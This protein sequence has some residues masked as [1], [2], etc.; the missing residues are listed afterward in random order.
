MVTALSE[1]G[2][3]VSL[4]RINNRVLIV[5]GGGCDVDRVD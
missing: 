1:I 5:L 3:Q 4:R 2:S